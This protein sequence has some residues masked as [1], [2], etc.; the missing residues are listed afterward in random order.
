MR[1]AKTAIRGIPAGHHW[2]NTAWYTKFFFGGGVLLGAHLARLE[3]AEAV[4]VITPPNAQ[5]QAHRPRPWKSI[6][7]ISR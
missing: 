5:P 3:L 2:H 7:G 4:R 1:L 6:T